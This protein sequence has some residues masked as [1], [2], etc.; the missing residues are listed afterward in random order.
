MNQDLQKETDRLKGQLEYAKLKK[1]IAELR[2]ELEEIEDYFNPY[3]RFFA[4]RH[5]EKECQKLTLWQQTDKKIGGDRAI[6]Q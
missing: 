5:L 6:G 2:K 3:T 1:E 4:R